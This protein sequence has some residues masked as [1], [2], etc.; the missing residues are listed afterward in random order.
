[1]WVDRA[2]NAVREAYDQF[3]K[4]TKQSDDAAYAA[5]AVLVRLNTRKHEVL[6]VIDELLSTETRDLYRAGL[7]LL[8]GEL[9]LSDENVSGILSESASSVEQLERLAAGLT[10]CRFQEGELSGP[11]P[12]AVVEA[13][14]I[15]DVQWLFEKLPWDAVECININLLRRRPKS[16]TEEA[17]AFL[18]NR[19][20]NGEAVKESIHLLLD[21][22]FPRTTPGHEFT[23]KDQFTADPLRLLK[24]M[25]DQFDN[26]SRLHLNVS[27]MPHGLPDS[28]RA[29]RSLVTGVAYMKLDDI[30]PA[31]AFADNPFRPRR[32]NRLK[33]GDRIHSRYFGLGTIKEVEREC[34]N[35]SIQVEFDEEGLHRF[36]LNHSLKT[37]LIDLGC[38]WLMA[39]FVRRSAKVNRTP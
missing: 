3:K 35:T 1:M 27:L 37:F 16:E 6:A 20:E 8:I 33:A 31:I 13:M 23:K 2:R 30:Y 38:Y 28:R 25:L 15:S 32:I 29:L 4:L 19:I 11:L 5:L 12:D 14:C 36:S 22:L 21:L 10:A 17:L 34:Y 9:G 24:V 39:L 18:F 7:L 26:N